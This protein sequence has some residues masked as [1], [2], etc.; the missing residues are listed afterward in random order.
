MIVTSGAS[1]T[2]VLPVTTDTGKPVVTADT[3]KEQYCYISRVEKIRDSIFILA[4]YVEF[5]NGKNVVEEAKKRHRADTVFDKAGKITDIFVPNDYFIVNDD[6]T[7]VRLYLPAATPVKMEQEFVTDKKAEINNYNYFS[8][9]YKNSLFLL[10][11][12]GTSIQ[13]VREVFLP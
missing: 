8:G 7:T 1:S 5:F 9:H 13:A 6:E 2:P 12:K 4:D 11:L 10:T 3:G